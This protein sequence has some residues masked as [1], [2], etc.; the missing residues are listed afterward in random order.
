M[1]LSPEIANQVFS[2]P[3]GER[4]ALAQQLLDSI[5]ESAMHRLDREFVAEL[6]RRRD[7]MIRGEELITDWR[8]ALD[9]IE[10]SLPLER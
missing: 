10:G 4:F 3:P 8:S 6:Q 9:A 7:E 2:L 5:D 1:D